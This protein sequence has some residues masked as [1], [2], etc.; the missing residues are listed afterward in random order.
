MSRRR[1]ELGRGAAGRRGQ[2]TP[3]KR[4]E[5]TIIFGT[6]PSV[7]SPG[8]VAVPDSVRQAEGFTL[9]PKGTCLVEM[10]S[11]HA[12]DIDS[13]VGRY[14]LANGSGFELIGRGGRRLGVVEDV[15][16]DPT[17]QRVDTMVVKRRASIGR[18]RVPPEDLAAVVPAAK[19]FVVAPGSSDALAHTTGRAVAS[20]ASAELRRLGTASAPLAAA[21]ARRFAALVGAGV[22]FV[23]ANWPATRRALVA[24]GAAVL[25]A[26]R[27]LRERE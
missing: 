3:R 16:L 12:F 17:T 24:A 13:T 15:V 25:D 22:A 4:A 1:S 6:P 5:L 20:S 27:R 2:A 18:A 26:V 23:R 14:W 10:T 11:H 8:T 9:A 19:L 21:G 7:D